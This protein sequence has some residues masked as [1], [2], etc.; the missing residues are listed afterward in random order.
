VNFGA[1]KRSGRVESVVDITPLVDVVFL[2]LIFLLVTTTFKNREHVFNLS[3]P[4]ASAQELTVRTEVPTVFVTKAGEFVFLKPPDADND[5]EQSDELTLEELE[6]RLMEL[7]ESQPGAVV[8]IKAQGT[9]SYQQVMDVMNLL[10]KVGLKEV[11]LPFRPAKV[12]AP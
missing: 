1:G 2:L 3:L 7:A 11:E 5:A 8:S 6:S 9:V 10:S 4:T 12:E